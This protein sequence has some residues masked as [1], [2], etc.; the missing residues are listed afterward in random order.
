MTENEKEAI[1]FAKKTKELMEY[2]L[3]KEVILEGYLDTSIALSFDD[4]KEMR[5]HLLAISHFKRW[6]D[7]TVNNGIILLNNHSKG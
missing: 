3:F 2:P 1:E 4:S 5:E 6:L 7:N